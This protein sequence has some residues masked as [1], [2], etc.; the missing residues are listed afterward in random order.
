M[1]RQT[2]RG[3]RPPSLAGEDEVLRRLLLWRLS[4]HVSLASGD[5][6]VRVLLS[7]TV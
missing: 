7:M 6:G 5:D 2:A 4:D 1:L 3:T